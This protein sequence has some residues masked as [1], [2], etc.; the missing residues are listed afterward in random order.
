MPAGRDPDSAPG[1]AAHEKRRP[2]TTR[3]GPNAKTSETRTL[4]LHAP[5][6]RAWQ[7]GPKRKPPTRDG[8]SSEIV[9]GNPP[10]I[11]AGP[12]SGKAGQAAAFASSFL[13]RSRS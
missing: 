7:G 9:K 5:A 11:A 2:P 13:S 6:R 1:K 4:A 3:D 12:A 8:P 10:R